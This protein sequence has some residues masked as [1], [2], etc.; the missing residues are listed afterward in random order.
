MTATHEVS[1]L[2]TIQY[3]VESELEA[4]DI[5]K[6]MI[7]HLQEYLKRRCLELVVD[8]AREVSP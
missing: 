8:E 1:L 6:D 3:P 5:A 2:L 4:S 7:D